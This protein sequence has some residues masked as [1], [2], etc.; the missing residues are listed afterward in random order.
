M[1]FKNN[2]KKVSVQFRAY[3]GICRENRK[4]TFLLHPLLM[5]LIQ[6]QQGQL[7]INYGKYDIIGPILKHSLSLNLN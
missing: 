3:L 5:L 1:T 4:D 6:L 7:K 2:F